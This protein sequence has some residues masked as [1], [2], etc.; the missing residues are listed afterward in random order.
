MI[1][2]KKNIDLYKSIFRGRNDVYA[3]RRVKDGRSGYMPA[4]KVDWTDYNKHKAQGCTFKDYKNKE[5]LP[6]DNSAIEGHLSG[7]ETILKLFDTC[8][9]YNIP[10]Y[11]ERSRSGNGGHLWVFFRLNRVAK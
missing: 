10:S 6:F 9:K 5:Y 1:K 8:C 7:K 4:Y 2:D 11:I 3:V